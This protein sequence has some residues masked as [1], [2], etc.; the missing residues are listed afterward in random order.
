[1][2]VPDSLRLPQ[3]DFPLSGQR[4]ADREVAAL[5]QQLD[6]VNVADFH[7]EISIGGRLRYR[8]EVNYLGSARSQWIN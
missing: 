4:E 8:K 2:P 1:M 3:V 6:V 7:L 5:V